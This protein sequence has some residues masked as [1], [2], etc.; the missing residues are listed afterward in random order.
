[1]TLYH[2]GGRH[3]LRCDDCRKTALTDELTPVN[4][5]AELGREGW[6]GKYGRTGWAHRCPDCVKANKE[7]NQ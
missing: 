5:V 6:R 7:N 3:G 2:H 4:V 1:M